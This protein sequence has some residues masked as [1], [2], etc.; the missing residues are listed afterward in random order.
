MQDYNNCMTFDDLFL[1]FSFEI[2]T[3]KH[4]KQIVSHSVAEWIL[5]KQTK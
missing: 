1:I 5:K 3:N 4:I 2:K